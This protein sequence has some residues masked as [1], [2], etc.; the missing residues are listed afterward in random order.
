[1]EAEAGGDEFMAVK[2]WVGA[3]VEPAEFKPS[4]GGDEVPDC[5]L[6]LEWVHGYR[7][8][9]CRQNLFYVASGKIVYPAA[10]AAVRLDAVAWQQKFMLEHNDGILALSVSPDRKLVATAS[11]GRRPT[12]VV[13]DPETMQT[14]QVIKGL[15]QPKTASKQFRM[16]PST[17]AMSHGSS[18]SAPW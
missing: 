3:I 18:G 11:Q 6:D 9:D 16:S 8:Q 13:W 2:P 10:H 5:N 4:K 1:M 14:K 7:A 17:L 15:H 12:I